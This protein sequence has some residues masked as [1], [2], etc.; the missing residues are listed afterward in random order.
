MYVTDQF[1]VTGPGLDDFDVP[2]PVA[3]VGDVHG[4]GQA[5]KTL[6]NE[7][8]ACAD[9]SHLVFLGDLVDRGPNNLLALDLALNW[10]A[11]PVTHL[12]GNHELM[13]AD[14]MEAAKGKTFPQKRFQP[15]RPDLWMMNG[16]DS[17]LDEVFTAMGAE[18]AETPTASLLA[19]DAF[20]T[21][22]GLNVATQVRDWANHATFGSLTCVH[23]GVARKHPLEHT[24]EK[25]Q[26]SHLDDDFHWAWVR[27]SFLTWQKGFHGQLITH[28]HT[29]PKTLHERSPRDEADLV[30]IL[31]RMTTNARL[32][33]DGGAGYG[34][35]VAGAVFQDKKVQLFWAP[36]NGLTY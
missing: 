36:C 12:P 17:F 19:M 18:L 33:L 4:Q 11:T 7:M 14:A 5:L 27:D 29:V 2:D 13:M 16:G 22:N 28:G 8:T 26:S 15:T 10:T 32:C 1:T 9:F 3:V 31:S 6:L 23:A 30:K 21:E 20:L 34:K 24:F 25:P 35:G